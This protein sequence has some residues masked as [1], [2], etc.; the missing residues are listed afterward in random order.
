MRL[1]AGGRTGSAEAARR[2]L[3]LELI[4]N[5]SRGL[6][7]L[8]PMIEVA[9]PRGRVAYGPIGASRPPLTTVS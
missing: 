7:W 8:E 4:R 1:V 5:G 9:T 2:N 6:Y 3:K